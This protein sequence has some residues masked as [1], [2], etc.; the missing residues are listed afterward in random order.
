MGP[1]ML[2]DLLIVGISIGVLYGLLALSV[3]LIYASLDIIHFAQGELYTMGAF[4]GLILFRFHI[5]FIPA[6]ILAAA[7]TAAFAYLLLKTIYNPILKISGG[8]SVRGLTFVVAGFGMANILQNSYW[9][10]WG[11]VSQS[12]NASFGSGISLG[13]MTLQPVYFIIMAVGI[14]LMCL[15]GFLFKKTKIGLAMRAVSYNK[16]LSSIMGIHV[17]AVMALAFCMAAFFSSVAGVLGAQ[18]TYVRYDMAATMLLKAFCSA[19]IGGMGNV[20]GAMLGGLMIGI[21]E[22]VGGYLIGAQYKDVISYAIMVLVLLI[23]P[24]GLFKMKTAQKA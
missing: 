19:V 4:L 1:T 20:F 14:V 15:L 2:F 11:V 10:A 22:S 18:L 5:P 6:M 8:F 23:R 3:S 21:V 16:E 7:G 12:Y 24:S 17:G 9:V 13:S